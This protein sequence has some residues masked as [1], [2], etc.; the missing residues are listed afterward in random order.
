M[1][2]RRASYQRAQ[3]VQQLA[4]RELADTRILSPTRGLLDQKFIEP[5]E[6][7]SVGTP[8]IRLQVVHVMRVHT[9]VSETD[10]SHVRASAKASVSLTG[11]PGQD[12][13]ALVEWVGVNADPQ[14]GNFPVKLILQ[15]ESELIRPGMT[16]TATIEG[17]Q[18][19]D[20]LLLP[21]R[22]LLDR[23]RRR[24]VFVAENG[25]ARLREPQLAAGLSNRLQ[26]LAGLVAGEQV[27]VSGQ[28]QLLNGSPV[29]VRAE[30]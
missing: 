3:A 26:I 27:I 16:A 12:Y 21:E 15:Q 7:V 18:R 10:I 29:N 9:W 25:V 20:V 14:T 13:P 4:E 28:S 22:A 17:L 19:Q 23:D 2:W 30:D 5:G 24:V 6:P 8:L 1:P 11:L